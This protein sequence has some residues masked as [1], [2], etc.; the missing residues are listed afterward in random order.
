MR[1]SLKYM[2]LAGMLLLPPITEGWAQRPGRTRTREPDRQ[3]LVRRWQAR[4]AWLLKA[5][6]GLNDQQMKQLSEVNQRFDARRRELVE[7]EARTRHSLRREVMKKDS[8]NAAVVDSLL[9]EQFRL[10]REQLDLN[11]AEQRELAGFLTPIQRAQYLGVQE[12][13]RREIDMFRMRGSS[14]FDAEPDSDRDRR[15][16]PSD[17]QRLTPA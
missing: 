17:W 12:Q 4:L 1:A 3:E 6:L 9:T 8:A 13:M 5:Q 10:D 16:P 11:E 7:Q 14:R 15:R 2:L